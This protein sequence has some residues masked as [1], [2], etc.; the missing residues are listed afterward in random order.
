MIGRVFWFAV[1]AGS[2]V[3]AAVKVQ[4]LARQ[5][6]PKAIGQRLGGSVVTVGDSV[7]SFAERARAAMAERE[8]ELRG[9]YHRGTSSDAFGRPD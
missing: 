2:A 6:T 8:A 5:A 7:R 4:E 9:I 1:G 3:Y